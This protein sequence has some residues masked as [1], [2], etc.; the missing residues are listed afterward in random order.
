MTI[1]E[2]ARMWTDI[3]DTAE[4]VVLA[5]RGE[6]SSATAPALSSLLDSFSVG[7]G[8]LSIDL[9]SATLL[10]PASERLLARWHA[11]AD[12]IPGI[13]HLHDSFAAAVT[14][15]VEKKCG[16]SHRPLATRDPLLSGALR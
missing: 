1:C 6:L 3:V 11:R 9:R 2:P 13:F 16:V 4:G 5:V 12:A 15:T 10:A 7:R 14:E 8:E